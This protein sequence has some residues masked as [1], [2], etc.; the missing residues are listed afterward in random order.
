[1]KTNHT[2]KRMVEA[3]EE[4]EEEARDATDAGQA[5]AY[6]VVSRSRAAVFA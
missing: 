6:R 5:G 3:A 2:K 4:E 1:M